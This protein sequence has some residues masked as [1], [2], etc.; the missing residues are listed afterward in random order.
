MKDE[1][2]ATVL[3]VEDD[4]DI[5]E[6]LS[7]WLQGQGYRV[8]A[9]GDG[10]EAVE[11]A[12]RECPGLVLMDMSLPTLDGLSATERILEIEELCHVPVIA[13]SAHIA[14]EWM[15]KA[16]AAGCRDYVTK[17]VDFASL[18]RLLKQYLQPHREHIP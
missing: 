2:A 4:E 14:G 6:M 9:T 10:A 5:R 1:D 3:V 7:H 16:L 11:V 15:H 13:C 12:R 17:P 18:G 8:I